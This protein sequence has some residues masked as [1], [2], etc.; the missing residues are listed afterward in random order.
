[1]PRITLQTLIAAPLER[2]FDLSLSVDLHQL[3]TS[4]TGEHIVAGVRAGV[5]N[6][7]ETVTWRAKHFGVWQNL[8]TLISE[9]RR[10]T[11]FC[12]EMLKGAFRSMRHEHHFADQNGKCL[13]TDYFDFESPMGP[14]GKLFN[15]LILTNYMTRFLEERNAV[16]KRVAES[17]EWKRILPQ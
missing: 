3:S 14:L 6:A 5:M 15:A 9:T 7:G 17:E 12:D 8:T 2:C 10:P 4:S 11:Y 13:M 1:M 16:I